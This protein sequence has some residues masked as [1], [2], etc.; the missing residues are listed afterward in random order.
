MNAQNASQES[1]RSAHMATQQAMQSA[2]WAS[3]QATMASNQAASLS[4]TGG[5]NP[6]MFG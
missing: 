3:Q 1:I 6:F 4:M 2:Q 5:M